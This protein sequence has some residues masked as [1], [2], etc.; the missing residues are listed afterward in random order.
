[1]V[2]AHSSYR[3]K[4]QNFP[5]PRNLI[6]ASIDVAEDATGGQPYILARLPACISKDML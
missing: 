6:A 1:M 5:S 4:Q 2:R 3:D